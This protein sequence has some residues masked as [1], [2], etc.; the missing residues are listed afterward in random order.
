MQNFTSV[1][2]VT[3]RMSRR[4][5][6][7]SPVIA[8]VII[9]AV[10]IAVAISVAFW[11]GGLASLFTRFERIEFGSAFAT[12]TAPAYTITFNGKSTGSADT[13]ITD[14]I[15]KARPLL[16]FDTGNFK[17]E[18]TV[19]PPGGSATLKTYARTGGLP[20]GAGILT[21]ADGISVATVSGATVKV[22]VIFS[23]SAP[24]VSGQAV[25][26]RVLTSGGQEYGKSV[27]LP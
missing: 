14:V 9:V 4:R 22:V 15:A 1:L 3:T 20:T 10:T 6:G 21:A 17:V 5:S 7:I 16:D 12:G 8:T 26:L 18:F 27:S 24:L 19:T 25:E 23:S 11:L 2:V 13:S